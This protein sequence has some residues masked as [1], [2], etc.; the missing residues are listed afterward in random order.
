M[1]ESFVSYKALLKCFRKVT[2]LY[3]HFLPQGT[4]KELKVVSSSYVFFPQA[5]MEG[6]SSGSHNDWLSEFE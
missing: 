1:C 4:V 6:L 3:L 2:G 5:Q